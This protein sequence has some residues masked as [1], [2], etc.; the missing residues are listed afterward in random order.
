MRYCWR[1]YGGWHQP[2]VLGHSQATWCCAQLQARDNYVQSHPQFHTGASKHFV[3]SAYTSCHWQPSICPFDLLLS[4]LWRQPKKIICDLLIDWLIDWLVW[5]RVVSPRAP[6]A[7]N[8]TAMTRTTI[9]TTPS[10]PGNSVTFANAR[11]YKPLWQGFQH[12]RWSL[13]S[14]E[15]RRFG[16]RWSLIFYSDSRPFLP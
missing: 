5:T 10:T 9:T 8:T 7:T 13:P 4:D 6:N 12:P 14:K 3:N 11:F 16:R 2:P 1:C 15:Y